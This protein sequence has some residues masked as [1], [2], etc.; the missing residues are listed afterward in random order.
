MQ[1]KKSIAEVR[2]DAEVYRLQCCKRVP[3]K[4]TKEPLVIQFMNLNYRSRF[5]NTHAS[6]AHINRTNWN[7][8]T[9]KMQWKISLVSVLDIMP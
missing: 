9:G 1:L 4:L 3:M 2:I 7:F 6:C 8:F 5:Q